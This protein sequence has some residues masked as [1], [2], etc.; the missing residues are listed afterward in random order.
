MSKITKEDVNNFA[1][2][3]NVLLSEEELNF[4][5]EFIKKNWQAILANPN[6]LNLE[7]YKNNYSEENFIKIKKLV[8]EY[9]IKYKNYL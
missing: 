6:M 7:R 1:K 8:R 4:T 3:N 9:S 2:K 5:Y